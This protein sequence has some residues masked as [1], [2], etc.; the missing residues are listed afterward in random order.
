MGR[1]CVKR[2]TGIIIKKHAPK[3]MKVSLLDSEL[4][5]INA[6]FHDDTLSR[7]SLVRYNAKPKESIVFISDIELLD[8]PMVLAKDDLLF[9]HHVLELCY[10]FLPLEFPVEDIF[11]LMMDLYTPHEYM[12]Q[13]IGKQLFLCKFFSLLGI[14]PEGEKFQKPHFH[15]IASTP[16]DILLQ[17]NIDLVTEN[18]MHEWLWHCIKTHPYADYF[19]TLHFIGKSTPL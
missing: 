12:Q 4:G 15:T 13:S 6:V 1:T 5:K 2:H 8:V 11:D 18:D 17:Q 3:N 19:K 14:Y 9:F 16:I 7:G 10:Y